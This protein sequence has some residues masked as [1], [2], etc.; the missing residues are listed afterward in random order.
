MCLNDCL[1]GKQVVE[2]PTFYVVRSAFDTCKQ[3]PVVPSISDGG[4]PAGDQR[5][6]DVNG[7]DG[8]NS[9]PTDDQPSVGASTSDTA[10]PQAAVK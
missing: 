3:F 10:E 2:F 4:K 8:E 5:G 1:H 6:N 9:K 7:G